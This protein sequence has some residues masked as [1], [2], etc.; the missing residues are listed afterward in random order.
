MT[1][2]PNQDRIQNVAEIIDPSSWATLDS[3]KRSAERS[4]KASD[5]AN[6]PYPERWQDR[7]S[8]AKASAIE[9]LYLAE[10][11]G[12]GAAQSQPS[13][14]AGT[15]IPPSPGPLRLL[16]RLNDWFLSQAPD[17]YRGCGLHIDVEATLAAVGAEPDLVRA[18]IANLRWVAAQAEHGEFDCLQLPEKLSEALD[19]AEDALSLVSPA[20]GDQWSVHAVA[21]RVADGFTS[22]NEPFDEAVGDQQRRY[23]EAARAVLSIDAA[24]PA[25]A[26]LGPGKPDEITAPPSPQGE[27]VWRPIESAPRDGT[28]DLFGYPLKA[29]T[30]P[31][32]L[33]DC[34]FHD[35][36]WSAWGDCGEDE[37]GWWPIARPTHWMF[38]PSPPGEAASP[39]SLGVSQ[40]EPLSVTSV[41]R[42]EEGASNANRA[43]T[44]PVAR[45]ET[46][47]EPSGRVKP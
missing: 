9:S 33:T 19:I 6:L 22:G 28:L 47:A 31:V 29:S 43:R 46:D 27:W 32:R 14:E 18:G 25:E 24:S 23:I 2:L 36:A 30:L 37:P 16:W 10:L 8:L 42:Q 1:S 15:H 7:P 13:A 17:H 34:E 26:E 35:G 44:G 39:R 40:D 4:D 5:K 20:R 45:P 3:Y 38:A 12:I 11:E 41:D 21:V